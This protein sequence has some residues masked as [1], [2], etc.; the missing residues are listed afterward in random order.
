MTSDL[1]QFRESMAFAAKGVDLTGFEVVG[2]DGPIGTVD[3]ASNDVR[4]NYVVVDTVEQLAGRRVVLPARTVERIDPAGRTLFVDRTRD[5]IRHA[6]DFDPEHKAR[7]SFED[8]LSGYY[9]GLYDT[10]L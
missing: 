7:A 6:P 5:D 4:M 10:G 2:K 8:A 1:W 3:K 9:H